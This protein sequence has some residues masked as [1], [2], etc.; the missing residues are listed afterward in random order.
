MLLKS[1][2]KKFNKYAVYYLF[3]LPSLIAYS[4]F[5]FYPLLRTI[6]FSFYRY[7]LRS[8]FFVGFRN[9]LNIIRNPIFLRALGNTCLFVLGIV[10][11]IIIFSILLSAVLVDMKDKSRTSYMGIFYLPSVTSIVT[12]S[13]VFKW[14]YDYRYGIVNYMMGLMGMDNI[15]WL[16]EKYTAIPSIIVMIVYLSIGGPTILHTAAMLAVPKTYYDAAKID[17]A[18]KW[19][20]LWKITVPLIRPTTL[21]LTVVLTIGSFQT[22]IIIHLMTL[23]GPFHRTTNLAFQL[24]LE[25]FSYTKYGLASTYGVVLLIIITILTYFQYKLFSKDIEY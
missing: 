13:I 23:G 3:L 25:A 19:Q 14:I 4:L 15:S 5:L 12:I 8:Y 9:Y 16:T 21:Y 17:G 22:F 2:K 18:T 1:L 7:T 20:T 11:S 10:P 6:F 24:S